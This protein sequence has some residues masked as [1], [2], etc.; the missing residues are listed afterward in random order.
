M[1]LQNIVRSFIPDRDILSIKPYGNGHINSTYKVVFSNSQNEYILQKINTNVFKSPNDIIQNHFKIQSFFQSDNSE[2]KIPHLIPTK[3]K[4]YLFTDENKDVWRLMNFI[5]DSYS[6]EVLTKNA[7]AYEAGKAFGWFLNQFSN[8]NPLEFKE[9]IKDFHSLTF[10]LNQFNDAILKDSANRLSK[11]LN[12]VDFYK[13]RELKLMQIEDL[14]QN[15]EIPV[16]LVHNDTKINNLLYRDHKAVAVIDLDTVGPGTIIF[17]YGDA[18]RT[19]CNTKAEDE[20]DIETVGFNM[21][22]F[23]CFTKGYLE[24]TKTVLTDAET[25]TMHMAPVYMTFIMGIRFLTDYLNGDVYYKTNY[26]NHN[27]IRS[28]VQKQLIEKMENRI[29]ELKSIIDKYK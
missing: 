4:E 28:L 3:E 25:E 16:R 29:D 17:D 26:D 7:Q 8:V 23:E 20:N 2:L 9:A 21:E 6:I 15:K 19:I 24:K 27:L 14:I 18:L 13:D 11:V 12:I 1:E 22:A 5:K 10:R